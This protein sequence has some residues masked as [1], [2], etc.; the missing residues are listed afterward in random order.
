M[1]QFSF[2]TD[3]GEVREMPGV[4]LVSS[5]VDYSVFNSAMLSSP[6]PGPEGDLDRRAA[7]AAVHFTMRRLG[8]S[9]WLCEEMLEPAARRRAEGVLARHGLR[10]MAEAPG[11][12]A[13]SLAP[14][15]RPLPALDCLRVGN[16]RT[17]LDFCH[18]ISIGF[19]LPYAVA[20]S[21]YGGARIWESGYQGWVGYR[22]GQ[23]VSTAATL[24]TAGV[25]GLYSVAT[26]PEH[27]RRGYGEAVARHALAA[28]RPDG[29]ADR[30]VLQSTPAGHALYERM[31]YRRLANFVIY[32]S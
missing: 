25:I 4:T 18:V 29:G 24:A 7:A 12:L 1:R 8:W 22:D 31:G 23:P 21:I 13:E 15:A 28:G 32:I 9:F 20:W 10:R 14:P 2:S 3:G 27:R 30:F 17:R 19:H 16:E 6:C 11:M 5:G 26:L